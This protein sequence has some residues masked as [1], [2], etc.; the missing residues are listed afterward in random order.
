[1]TPLHE[2]RTVLCH[3]A[4]IFL[5]GSFSLATEFDGGTGEPNDPYQIATAEQLI[6][7]GSDP[8]LLDKHFILI[9]DIDLDPNLPGGRVF[10]RALIAPDANEA[11]GFQSTEFAGD[12]DGNSRKIA[13]LIIDGNTVGYVGLFGGVGQKGKIHDLNLQNVSVRGSSHVGWLV[14]CNLGTIS[15][16]QVSARISS[17]TRAL[18]LGALVGRNEGALANCQARGVVSGGDYS[19]YLGGLAGCNGFAQGGASIVSCHAVGLVTG[20][21]ECVAL[22]GLAGA[23]KRTITDSDAGGLVSSGDK[24]WDIGGLV[25]WNRGEISGSHASALMIAGTDSIRI[26]GLVGCMGL[27]RP[28]APKEIESVSQG[29]ITACYAS[30]SVCSGDRSSEV[31]GLVG[32][33]WG[34]IQSCYATGSV[35]AGEDANGLGG[36]VGVNGGVPVLDSYARGSVWGGDRSRNLG[37]LVGENGHRFSEVVHCYAAGSVAAA[38]DA[39]GLGGLVA[40]NAGWV[41]GYY[42]AALDGGGPENGMGVPLLDEQI[43]QQA[44]FIRWDFDKIWM[45]CEGR[46]YPHLQWERINCTK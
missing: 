34:W 13:N 23:N 36:L 33:S 16:C 46:D 26:G 42:L 39:D 22:G 38:K 10:T 29:R 11:L 25:G 21:Q 4:I 27:P 3:I 43:R 40:A 17:D 41:D 18:F 44:S 5:M 6:T 24:C 31:G 7:I 15:D 28:S 14:G 1:M 35:C 2:H 20:G 32:L 45:I 37:G 30:G 8:S 9:N 12:F 19:A